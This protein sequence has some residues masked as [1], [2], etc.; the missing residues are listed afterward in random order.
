MHPARALTW[1]IQTTQ[2]AAGAAQTRVADGLRASS[3]LLFPPCCAFCGEGLDGA[4]PLRVMLCGACVARLVAPRRTA[5]RRCASPL[6]LLWGDLNRCPRCLDRRYFF[7]RAEA[8]GDYRGHMRQAVLWM[9]RHHYE[10]L[11]RAVGLLLAERVFNELGSWEPDLVIPVPM[12]W[13]RRLKRGTNTARVL[14]G[15][16]AQRL[17]LPMSTQVLRCRRKSRKQGTLRPAER[18]RNIRGAFCISRGYDITDKRVLLIDDIL[19]TGATASE[20]ARML[21]RAGA[22]GVAVAVVARGIGHL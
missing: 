13:W 3:N 6:P 18:L 4:S 21:R 1:L 2:G 20:A 17:A 8:L 10:P 7:D 9:K 12:H 5:C 19:T 15:A 14:G 11:T 16:V 22:A